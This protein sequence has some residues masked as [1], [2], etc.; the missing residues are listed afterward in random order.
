MA[1]HAVDDLPTLP[2]VP[3]PHATIAEVQLFLVEYLKIKAGMNEPT[4]AEKARELRVD[5]RDL[6][7]QDEADL[8]TIFGIYGKGLYNHIQDS[9]WGRVSLTD[10]Q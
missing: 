10:F 6:L 5:G 9:I 2:P 8:K 7:G 1:S 3:P 4:A